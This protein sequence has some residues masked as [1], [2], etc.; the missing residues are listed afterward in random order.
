MTPRFLADADFNQEIV[1]GLR[2][3][4][5]AIDFSDALAAEVS[6]RDIR[7][8]PATSWATPGA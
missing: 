6:E 2:R 5:R 3:G 4:E 8:S 7:R 1:L